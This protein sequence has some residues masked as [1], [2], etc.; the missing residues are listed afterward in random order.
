MKIGKTSLLAQLN[1]GLLTLNLSELALYDGKG[2]GTV[3]VDAR[4]EQARITKVFSLTGLQLQPFLTDAADFDKLEGTGNFELDISTTGISQKTFVGALNGN[5]SILFSDG[6]I[7]GINLAA[8]ARNVTSAFTGSG[9]VQK[10]DF[11]ELSGTYTIKNGLLENKDLKL[12]NPFIQVS[13][14]G[15]VNIPPKTQN[16][17]L[18][19]KLTASAQGQGGSEAAGIVVPLKITGT[20][21]DPKFAPDLAGVISNV[22]DPNALKEKIEEAGKEKLQENLKGGLKEGLEGGLKGLGGMLGGKK[23]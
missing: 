10:T 13:G 17:R 2:K 21:N 3:S 12:L 15:Q 18:E 11:A 9:E 16:Y 1:D 20:W 7:N 6:A 23:N 14:S 5:G 22:A 8:M 19:P 4:R